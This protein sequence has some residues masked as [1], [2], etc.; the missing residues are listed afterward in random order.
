MTASRFQ[1]FHGLIY[2]RRNSTT[3]AHEKEENRETT[4]FSEMDAELPGWET[5]RRTCARRS[6][7]IICAW[8]GADRGVARGRRHRDGRVLVRLREEETICCRRGV[9]ARFRALQDDGQM[10]RW[11][12]AAP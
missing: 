8:K 2:S 7:R 12:C 3:I 1:I 5:R 11:R 10:D 6:I 4:Q 9:P